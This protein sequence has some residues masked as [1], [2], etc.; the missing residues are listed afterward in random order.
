MNSVDVLLRREAVCFTIYTAQRSEGKT[1]TATRCFPSITAATE[2]LDNTDMLNASGF[3]IVA[4]GSETLVH[5]RR[6][7]LSY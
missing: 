4:P 5:K 6:R 2:A 7:G 3:Q 1:D